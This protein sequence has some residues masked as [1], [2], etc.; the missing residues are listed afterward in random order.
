[1]YK[2]RYEEILVDESAGQR[3]GEKQ[4]I[5]HSIALLRLAQA[6]GNKS[7]EASDALAFVNRLWSYLLEE[8]SRPE[9]ALPAELKARLI[10]IGIWVLRESDAI[11]DQKS[12]NFAGLIDVSRTIAEGLT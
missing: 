3:D 7:R 11:G 10:S 8:L 2:F 1:M 4:A 12:E 6:A 9:N 5:E